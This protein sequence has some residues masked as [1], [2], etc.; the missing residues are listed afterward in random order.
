MFSLQFLKDVL[1]VLLMS[2]SSRMAPFFVSPSCAKCC[3]FSRELIAEGK[4]GGL[5]IFQDRPKAFD[6]WSELSNT[7]PSMNRIQTCLNWIDVDVHHLE[8]A[9]PLEF[10]SVSV[11]AQGPLRAA[12]RAEVK[13]GQSTISVTVCV[14]C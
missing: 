11:V 6:A 8:I 13:Y 12:V 10:S 1:P 3:L 2:N 7:I 4:T 14:S 5:V 9:Q